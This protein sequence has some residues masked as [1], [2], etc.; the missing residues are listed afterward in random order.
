VHSEAG[1]GTKFKVYLPVT[2]KVDQLTE[3]E[4]RHE[5]PSGHG[6]TILV[7]DDDVAVCQ[8]TKDTLLMYGYQVITANDGAEGVALFAQHKEEINLVLI[9]MMMPF[10]G[11]PATIRVLQKLNPHVKVIAESGPRTIGEPTMDEDIKVND[12]LSK[13]YT[14]ETL[15][16]TMRKVLLDE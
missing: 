9:D 3:D 16:C 1:K 11:G 8:I 4:R 10:L 12:T 6:E 5:Y 13:P 2:E 7:I 14:A 15:L